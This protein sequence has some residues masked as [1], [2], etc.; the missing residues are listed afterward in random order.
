MLQLGTLM[1]VMVGP[2]NVC[3]CSQS[4]RWNLS[5]ASWEENVKTAFDDMEA[6]VLASSLVDEDVE[7]YL[8]AA[9][10]REDLGG[11]IHG[12]LADA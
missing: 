10:L 3:G 4:A 6:A 5:A 1:S 7:E 11:L 8:V 2:D 12:T 9:V